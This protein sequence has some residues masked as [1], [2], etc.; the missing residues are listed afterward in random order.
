M[1]FYFSLK[2]P[3]KQLFPNNSPVQQLTDTA[4]CVL[5]L[6]SRREDAAG[7]GNVLESRIPGF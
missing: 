7:W 3:L 2:P 1:V 6:N 4:L 5:S